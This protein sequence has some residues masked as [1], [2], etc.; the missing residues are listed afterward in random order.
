MLASEVCVKPETY[1]VRIYRRTRD[2]P[3][4]VLGVVEAPGKGRWARFGSL[5]DLVAILGAPRS[6]LRRRT[7]TASDTCHKQMLGGCKRRPLV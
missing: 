6:H 4:K 7:A 3:R 2:E 5:A 1:V